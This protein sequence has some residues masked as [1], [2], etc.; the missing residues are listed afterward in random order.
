MVMRLCQLATREYQSDSSSTL[1][2]SSFA[3]GPRGD[4]LRRNCPRFQL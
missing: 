1:R 4:P 2:C 3:F